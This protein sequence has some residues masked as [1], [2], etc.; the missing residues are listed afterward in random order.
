MT[1]I[2]VLPPRMLTRQHLIA[3]YRELPRVFGL[4]QR[5]HE[6]G[7]TPQQAPL[8][9]TLGRGHVTFFYDK[10]AWCAERHTELVEEMDRRGYAARLRL[11]YERQRMA[12]P[13]SLW[14]DWEP[15]PE[16]LELNLSRLAERD[17]E[18]YSDLKKTLFFCRDFRHRGLTQSGDAHQPRRLT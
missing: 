6:R 9:Y 16:D 3:E 4:A 18:I 12:M 8:R 17:P 2:N 15:S 7:W 1:R 13:V 11:D 5:A 10:L 14:R